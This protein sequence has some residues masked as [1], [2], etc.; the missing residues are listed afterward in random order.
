MGSFHSLSIGTGPRIRFIRKTPAAVPPKPKSR[1]IAISVPPTPPGPR[2]TSP[3]RFA[4][5]AHAAVR[6]GFVSPPH[7]A[8]RQTPENRQM[9]HPSARADRFAAPVPAAR[10]ATSNQR[11]LQPPA[12]GLGSFHSF[13]FAR[14]RTLRSGSFRNLSAPTPRRNM[15]ISTL[16]LALDPAAANQPPTGRTLFRVAIAIPAHLRGT[17]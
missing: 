8:R 12:S 16:T 11:Q 1:K 15:C 10:R 7:R 17:L 4:P 13:R 3:I 6:V 2:P 14:I 5:P 9:C